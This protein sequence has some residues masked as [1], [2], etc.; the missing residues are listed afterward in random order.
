MNIQKQFCNYEL[1]LLTKEHGFDEECLGHYTSE[2]ELL[3][4][5]NYS[6]V[7]AN[8]LDMIKKNF[9]SSG[10]MKEMCKAPL[11]QQLTQWFREKHGIHIHIC[12]FIETIKWNADIY[13]ISKEYSL[14]NIPMSLQSNT[15]QE[16]LTQA[17]FE[18]FKLIKK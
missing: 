5:I 3:T 16:A 10:Y 8:I 2:K 9:N 18:S 17:L 13:D 14:M 12:Y 1:S 11:Y 4:V 7:D 6:E 15:Y